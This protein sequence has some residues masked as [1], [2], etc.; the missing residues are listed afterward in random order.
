MKGKISSPTATIRQAGKPD[1]LACRSRKMVAVTRPSEDP[2]MARTA[3][4]LLIV[5]LLGV[6]L[7]IPSARAQSPAPLPAA[8]SPSPAVRRDLA[9]LLDDPNA[10]PAPLPAPSAS[11]PLNGWEPDFLKTLPQPPDQPGSLF[12]P[13][14]Q[15]GPPPADL[16]HYFEQDALLDP[17]RWG[18]LGWFTDIQIQAIHPT[19][20]FGQF[21]HGVGPNDSPQVALGAA[22]QNWTVAPRIEI[23]YRLPSGFGG[24]SFSDQFF[25]TSGSGPF[26]GPAGTLTR[27]THFGV[28]Y[29][30]WD[31]ISPEYTQWTNWSMT[32]RAGVRLAET[33]TNTHVD[34]SFASAG[35]GT[36]I[37]SE[38]ASNYT[39]GAGP[40][41]G[42]ML[43]RKFPASGF[44]LIAKFDIANTFTRERSLFSA[45]NTSGNRTVFTQNYWQQVPILN[46]QLGVGWQPPANPNISLY[47]G[48]IY[49]FWWQVGTNSNITPLTG[50]TRAAFDNQGIVFQAK[51]AF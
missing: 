43:D 24:F 46:Y 41:V 36:G 19:L 40:H 30:D 32:W 17:P 37:V 50:G 18:N 15:P 7:A 3:R 10:L 29:S 20:F 48:Y 31:Y 11:A 25:T 34:Q 23:G 1:P 49:E 5:G 4:R 27:T 21:R 6:V 28:N 16:E 14:P 45:T 22:K 51:I 39:V 47:A 44:S 13:T 42:L 12:Q 8:A 33:W 26:V 9:E 38:Q 35:S 2:V